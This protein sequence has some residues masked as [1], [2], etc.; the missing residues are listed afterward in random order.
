MET[1]FC[2]FHKQGPLKDP[3]ECTECKSK[4]LT[5]EEALEYQICMTPEN[6][7]EG[8]YEVIDITPSQEVPKN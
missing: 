4:D 5:R 6:V 2:I 3:L 8:E 1:Y 7:P